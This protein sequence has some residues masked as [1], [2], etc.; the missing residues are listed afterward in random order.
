MNSTQE[1]GDSKL[2]EK[3]KRKSKPKN[4]A[5]NNNFRTLLIVFTIFMAI[6]FSMILGG[7]LVQGGQR[8]SF[9][10][11]AT[12]IQGTNDVRIT[13]ISASATQAVLDATATAEVAATQTDSP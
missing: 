9:S 5:K 4:S 3:Q 6:I 11:S 2:S 1:T 10:A 8:N 12:S 13:E 7:F